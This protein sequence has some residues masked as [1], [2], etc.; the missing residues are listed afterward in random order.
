MDGITQR[1]GTSTVLSPHFLPE[2]ATLLV[3]FVV[4]ALHGVTTEENVTAE[5]KCEDV[6]ISYVHYDAGGPSVN[7]REG[8]NGEYVIIE[9]RGCKAVNL[10]GWELKDDTNHVYVFPSIILKPGASVKVHTGYG[11]DTDTDLYWGRR[12]PVRNNNGDTAY[13]YDSHGNLVDS[14]SWTGKEGGSVSC[15]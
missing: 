9:N 3:L 2:L 14:C 13:L 8:L 6:V 10:E 11:A 4:R 12:T 1:L 5:E 15:H 7:D